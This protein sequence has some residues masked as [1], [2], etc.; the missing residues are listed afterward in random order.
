MWVSRFIFRFFF[1]FSAWKNPSFVGFKTLKL[2]EGEKIKCE[3]IFA[4]KKWGV[5]L[6]NIVFTKL[7]PCIFFVFFQTN[8][9]CRY[10]IYGMQDEQNLERVRLTFDKFN[11]PMADKQCSDGYLKVRVENPIKTGSNWFIL[12]CWTRAQNPFT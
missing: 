5:K 7:T 2:V 9:V 4:R 10:F 12:V 3:V 6:P 8:I 11:V 1:K